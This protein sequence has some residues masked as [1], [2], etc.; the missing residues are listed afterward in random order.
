MGMKRRTSHC[1]SGAVSVSRCLVYIAAA[2]RKLDLAK[3]C[4]NQDSP[5]CSLLVCPA[6]Y[7]AISLTLAHHEERCAGMRLLLPLFTRLPRRRVFSENEL[8]RGVI[9]GNR[10]SG[11]LDFRNLGEEGRQR[12]SRPRQYLLDLLRSSASLSYCSNSPPLLHL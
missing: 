9:P 4:S 5:P 1:D 8:P 2:H 7:D 10:A 3:T 12:L 6:G 11:I